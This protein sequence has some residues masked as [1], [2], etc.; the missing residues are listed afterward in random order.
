VFTCPVKVKIPKWAPWLRLRL[1]Q[2]WSRWERGALALWLPCCEKGKP[3][4]GL[5]LVMALKLKQQSGEW[6]K[7]ERCKPGGSLNIRTVFLLSWLLNLAYFCCGGR[8]G[9]C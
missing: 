6:V 8:E 1:Q 9:G 4:T 7:R 3:K 2:S 5:T